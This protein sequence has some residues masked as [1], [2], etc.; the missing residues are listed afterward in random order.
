MDALTTM[1][2]QIRAGRGGEPIYGIKKR[3]IVFLC[4]I[5]GGFL[6]WAIV[7]PRNVDLIV[8]PSLHKDVRYYPAKNVRLSD[9]VSLRFALYD[10][11]CGYVQICLSTGWANIF[12]TALRDIQ[13][14][15]NGQPAK[16][17]SM[18]CNSYWKGNYFCILLENMA[19]DALI[20]F[21]YQGRTVLLE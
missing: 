3:H 14:S 20:S 6:C 1:G 12:S 5:L 2:M 21:T 10:N 15:I 17:Y 7:F 11:E 13:I 16:R 8:T 19:P 9:R 4:L 18:N